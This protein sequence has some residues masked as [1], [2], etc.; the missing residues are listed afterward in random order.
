MTTAN[1]H[2]KIT[3]V[4]YNITRVKAEKVLVQ[5]PSLRLGLA[6]S[7]VAGLADGRSVFGAVTQRCPL[8]AAKASAAGNQR[9]GELFSHSLRIDSRPASYRLRQ[10]PCAALALGQ[11]TI[12]HP[13]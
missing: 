9:V 11:K 10:R 6:A 2:I 7:N 12:R 1:T 5:T 3:V 8:T 13:G 4:R